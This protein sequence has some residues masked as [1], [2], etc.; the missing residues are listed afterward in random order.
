MFIYEVSSSQATNA[1]QAPISLDWITPCRDNGF[2]WGVQCIHQVL[3][4]PCIDFLRSRGKKLK[5]LKT[6]KSKILGYESMEDINK[7]FGRFEASHVFNV[8]SIFLCVNE[9]FLQHE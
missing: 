3:K 1:T 2:E 5:Y 8:V 4:R 9:V 7:S 6:H